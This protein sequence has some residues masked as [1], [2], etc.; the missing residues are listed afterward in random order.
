MSASHTR[1]F[2]SSWCP[3]CNVE[4]AN[5]GT[6]PNASILTSR[7][8]RS[9]YVEDRAHKT[10]Q[11]DVR[12]CRP[13]YFSPISGYISQVPFTYQE[14]CGT[15][16]RYEACNNEAYLIDGSASSPHTLPVSHVACPPAHSTNHDQLR[17]PAGSGS[18]I[19]LSPSQLLWNCRP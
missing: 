3:G 17:S 4:S 10:S 18:S 11:N 16:W 19:L 6:I 14:D 13:A 2:L 12:V 5:S 1:Y 7:Q 15:R 8:L 9:R